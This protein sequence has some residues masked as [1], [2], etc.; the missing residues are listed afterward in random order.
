MGI[1][2]HTDGLK[3]RH[4]GGGKRKMASSNPGLTVEPNQKTTNEEAGKPM[5]ATITPLQR[6]KQGNLFET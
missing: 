6:N 4:K 2:V 3:Y 1:R 5:K